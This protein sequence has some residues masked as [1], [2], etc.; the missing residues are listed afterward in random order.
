MISSLLVLEK[1]ERG[2]RAREGEVVTLIL[3]LIYYHIAKLVQNDCVF[4][5]HCV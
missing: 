2:V 3:R 5:T 4:Y 1:A